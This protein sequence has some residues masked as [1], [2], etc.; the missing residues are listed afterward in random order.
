MHNAPRITGGP[1][2]LCLRGYAPSTLNRYLADIIVHLPVDQQVIGVDASSGRA[3]A[4]PS[5]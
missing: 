5:P 4:A 1:S 2:T 3:R